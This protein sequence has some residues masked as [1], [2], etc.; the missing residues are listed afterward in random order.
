MIVT[1]EKSKCWDQILSLCHFV[2]HKAHTDWLEIA[3]LYTYKT[4]FVPYRE[5]NL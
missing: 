5:D 4:S 3:K 2:H 1:E